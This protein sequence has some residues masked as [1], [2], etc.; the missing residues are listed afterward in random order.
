MG[1][2][3]LW[4]NWFCYLISNQDD[5]LGEDDDEDDEDD[6]SP[7]AVQQQAIQEEAPVQADT[8]VDTIQAD[9]ATPEVYEDEQQFGKRN[10]RMKKLF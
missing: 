8:V 2:M 4:S 5:V 10:L 6:V 1:K 9:A 3:C 7:A